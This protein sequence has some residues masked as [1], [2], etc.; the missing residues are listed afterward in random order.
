M[1]RLQFWKE[2]KNEIEE[3]VNDINKSSNPNIKEYLITKVD[4]I[5]GKYLYDI[6]IDDLS[7]EI[8]N[9]KID[10]EKVNTKK[11]FE[12]SESNTVNIINQYLI[13]VSRYPVLKPQEEYDLFKRYSNGEKELRDTIYNSNLRL[14]TKMAGKY[15]YTGVPYLDLVQEGNL[16]LLV[17]ID[18]FDVEKGFKFSTYAT[19]WIKQYISSSIADVI[20][21]FHVPHHIDYLLKRI[22]KANHD[23]IQQNGREASVEELA[24]ETE[25]S[26]DNIKLVLERTA[27]PIS[28]YEPVGEDKEYYEVMQAEYGLTT[29]E[30]SMND[31]LR[32]DILSIMDVLDDREKEIILKRFGFN[33]DI[34]TSQDELAK[35]YDVS[36]QRVQQLEK[37]AIKKLYK[38]A[39]R[40][41]LNEYLEY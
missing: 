38:A 12:V 7:K 25:T 6:N 18:K 32:N 37:R 4:I 36:I 28:I 11:Q 29:E 16:G 34:I 33:N 23:M 41:K 39:S 40:K 10:L 24:K 8:N 14:V 9:L 1:N 3:M 30:I 35:K 13:D 22:T 31:S 17:A 2:N 27:T 20:N 15:T 21:P 5:A 26:V 19:P